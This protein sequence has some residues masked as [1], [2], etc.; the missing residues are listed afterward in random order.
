MHGKSAAARGGEV[1]EAPV[2]AHRR[3]FLRRRRFWLNWLMHRGSRR[4]ESTRA[5][6]GVARCTMPL[7]FVS[8]ASPRAW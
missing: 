2:S 7:R 6:A 1:E 3:R 4:A 8:S 5:T